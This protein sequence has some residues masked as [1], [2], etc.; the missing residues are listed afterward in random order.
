MT[1]QPSKGLSTAMRG[2]GHCW[3]QYLDSLDWHHVLTLT[4]KASLKADHL[5]DRIVYR[6]FRTLERVAQRRLDWFLALERSHGGE[7]HHAH[8]LI[9]GTWQL[10][11][12][13]IQ[14]HWQLGFS[15][16][17]VFDP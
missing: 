17:T 15:R 13:E 6:Y 8:A 5:R 11:V 3:A 12:D 14:S 1:S 10:A 16:V 9:A 2:L 4:T 7:H